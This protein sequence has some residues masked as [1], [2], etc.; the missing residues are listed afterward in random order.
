MKQCYTCKIM[1]PFEQFQKRVKNKDGLD[2]KCKECSSAYHKKIYENNE[3][4]RQNVR[5]AEKRAIARNKKIVEEY[6]EK[7]PCVDCNIS[8]IEVLS[9]DHIIGQKR[10]NIAD[11]VQ[12]GVGE[13][14]LLNEIAKCEIVCM[15]CHTKRTKRRNRELV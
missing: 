8:D 15:N 14:T 10:F 1:K 2:H 7:H 9:F 13:E 5:E 4:R 12:R 3:K 6:K 11:G